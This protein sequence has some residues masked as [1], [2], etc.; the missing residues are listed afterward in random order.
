MTKTDTNYIYECGNFKVIKTMVNCKKYAIYKAQF[1]LLCKNG[2][3]NIIRLLKTVLKKICIENTNAISAAA[4]GG[5][6]PIIRYLLNHGVKIDRS[7]KCA[8]IAAAANGHLDTIKYLKRKV[9]VYILTMIGL[10]I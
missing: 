3:L 10:Q 4:E 5:H 1:E 7:N 6:I 2:H 8:I 9:Q